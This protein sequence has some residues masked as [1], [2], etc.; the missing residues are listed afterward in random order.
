MAHPLTHVVHDAAQLINL[1]E[2]VMNK[3]T[4]PMLL[5]LY[6]FS[7]ALWQ[8][9][10]RINRD[11]VISAEHKRLLTELY[12]RVGVLEA[13]MPQHWTTG[14]VQAVTAMAG[15]STGMQ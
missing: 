8:V 7:Q 4:T 15:I 6:Q 2:R 9:L 12:E 14:R 11:K 10:E 5:L 3:H 1:I 13:K